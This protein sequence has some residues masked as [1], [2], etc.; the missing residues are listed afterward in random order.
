MANANMVEKRRVMPR[1]ISQR[2]WLVALSAVLAGC[3]GTRDTFLGTRVEDTCGGQWPICD[4]IAGCLLGDQSY[5]TGRFPGDRVIGIHLF[6]PSTVTLSFLLEDVGASG[7]QTSINFFEDRCRSRVRVELTG[8][9]FVGEADKAGFVKREA[10]LTGK[11]DHL[12][13][14]SSDAQA[15]YLLK[16]DVVPVRLK[17]ID[18]GP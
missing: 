15:H 10:D 8:K 11:D 16:V 17:G 13:E 14:F 7:T 4:R 5:I 1:L 12:I 6:E 2:V 3:S 18:N 9:A